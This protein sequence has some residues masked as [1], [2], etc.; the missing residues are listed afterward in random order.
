[1]NVVFID[2]TNNYPFAVS[3]ANSKIEYMSKGLLEQ[4]SSI[5]VLNTR[6]GYNERLIEGNKNGIDYVLFKKGNSIQYVKNFFL[7]YKI[8]KRSRKDCDNYVIF[9]STFSLLMLLDIFIAKLIGYKAL[10]LF[11]EMR[12]TLR[13]NNSIIKRLDAYVLDYIIGYFCDAI[14]PISHYIEKFSSRFHKPIFKIPVLADF[15]Y[16]DSIPLLHTNEKY[17]LYCGAS[18]YDDVINKIIDSIIL[19]QDK[20]LKFKLILYGNQQRINIIKQKIIDGKLEDRC[21]VLEDLSQYELFK[22]YKNACALL[23]PLNPHNI[24]DSVRFSQKIAEYVSTKVPIITV[25]VGEIPYYFTNHK[26]AIFMDDFSKESLLNIYNSILKNNIL[27][28]EIG[29]NGYYVGNKYFNYKSCMKDFVS[30][31]KQ[32]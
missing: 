31:I 23:I 9:A 10:F 5:K 7:F 13:T 17:L 12:T 14:L 24:Q 1:M 21:V 15:E 4:K 25:N 27:L 30:F 32:L 11:H 19:C 6:S 8:L 29:I 2:V 26:S 3:A 22:L 18:A 28:K 16:F 20:T